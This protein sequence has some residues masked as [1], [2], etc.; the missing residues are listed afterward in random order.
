[1]VRKLSNRRYAVLT[2]ASVLMAMLL[3]MVMPGSVHA[4]QHKHT[5]RHPHTRRHHAHKKPLPSASG[6]GVSSQGEP[7]SFNV[8]A[9]NSKTD[10]ATGTF[11]VTTPSGDGF[12]QGNLTCL[13]VA[14]GPDG[15]R[16][17]NFAGPVT[18]TNQPD[19]VFGAFDITDS[20][21]PNGAGDLLNAY[22]AS[23][24][25]CSTPSGGPDNQPLQ[26]GNVVVNTGT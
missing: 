13:R 14:K 22:V 5:A 4:K 7:F 10:A 12:V 1:M 25:Q 8:Q 3:V 24:A 19:H 9:N 15:S 6:Q 26:S 20:G 17:A 18:N 11:L 2:L 23:S 16:F 21:Q